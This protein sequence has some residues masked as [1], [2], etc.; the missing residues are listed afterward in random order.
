MPEPCRFWHSRHAGLKPG[1]GRSDNKTVMPACRPRSLALLA[2][3]AALALAPPA[4]ASYNA[5]IAALQVGLQGRGLYSGT[6]D[7]VKGA[8]TTAA[9]KRFQRRAG[10]PV[11]GVVGPSTRKAL[12]R[13]GRHVLGSRPLRRGQSGWDVAAL[14]FL[15]AWHGFPSA[16]IDGGLGAATA[17]TRGSTSSRRKAR[18]WP[19]PLR[20]ASSTPPSRAAAGGTWS[21]CSTATAFGRF[22]RTFRR[23]T[24][25]AARPLPRAP[26][27]ASSAP[28]A[29]RPVRT[30]ISRSG[31]AAPPSIRA[32]PS[33]D[34]PGVGSFP[35]GL[36]PDRMRWTNRPTFQQVISFATHRPR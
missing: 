17:S 5:G 7:G 31:S 10:L 28:P 23:S 30:S 21:S 4:A 6:I 9:V 32:A 13:F 14:Q 20:G 16:T 12:G 11:D 29:T 35:G 2:V 26:D 24:P 33:R 22:T 15:L 27:S 8:D 25:T 18:P 19:Q 36:L 34:P 1:P 3:L